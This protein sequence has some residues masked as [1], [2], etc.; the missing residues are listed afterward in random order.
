[1]YRLESVS[2]RIVLSILISFFL[3]IF[4]TTSVYSAENGG[5]SATLADF[6]GEVYLQKIGEDVWLPV[7]KRPSNKSSKK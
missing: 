5:F 7:E 6:E 2:V 1:M 4:P 3:T